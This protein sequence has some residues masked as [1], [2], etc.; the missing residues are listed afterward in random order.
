MSNIGKLN[1]ADMSDELRELRGS[2]KTLN[3]Q[4]EIRI[5]KKSHSENPNAPTHEVLGRSADGNFE[6]VGAAWLK[7]ITRGERE[8]REFLSANIDDPSF[9]YPL[10]FAVFRDTPGEW[11]ATWRRRQ[12]AT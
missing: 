7:T 3:F 2:I 4:I 5:R 6:I 11:I 10:N 9:P 12:A 8:G 1:S